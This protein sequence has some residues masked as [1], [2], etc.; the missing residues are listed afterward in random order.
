[1]EIEDLRFLLDSNQ[2][3]AFLWRLVSECGIYRASPNEYMERFEGQRDIGLWLLAEIHA[4][5]GKWYS[6]MAKE[7]QD[8]DKYYSEKKAAE[9]KK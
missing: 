3:R 8:R 6:L 5:P 2:G 7:A 9:D 1:M 4:V